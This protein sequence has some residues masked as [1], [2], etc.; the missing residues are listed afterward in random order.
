MRALGKWGTPRKCNGKSRFEKDGRCRKISKRKDG[1][2][3]RLFT[4]SECVSS[5]EWVRTLPREPYHTI[6][7]YIYIYRFLGGCSTVLHISGNNTPPHGQPRV[8]FI[9]VKLV[10][11]GASTKLFASILF[12]QKAKVLLTPILIMAFRT[13]SYN[14]LSKPASISKRIGPLVKISFCWSSCPAGM[15]ISER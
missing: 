11:V 8:V 14:V 15:D 1:D 3:R 12:I 10:T 9:T 4:F 7:V 5:C 2:F 6:A 13:S